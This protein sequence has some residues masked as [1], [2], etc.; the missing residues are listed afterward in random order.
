M[1]GGIDS[2]KGTGRDIA[3]ISDKVGSLGMPQPV[4]KLHS[5]HV[6][7]GQAKAYH[8]LG[9]LDLPTTTA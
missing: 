2:N 5:G 4:I 3:A 9:H 7:V 8:S 1:F 6:R